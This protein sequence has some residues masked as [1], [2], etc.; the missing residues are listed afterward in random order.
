MKWQDVLL[1]IAQQ[2]SWYLIEQD[3]ISHL[4]HEMLTVSLHQEHEVIVQWQP[5]LDVNTSWQPSKDVNLSSQPAKEV[6]TS[7]QPATLVNAPWQPAKIATTSGQP[8]GEMKVPWQQGQI[9][10]ARREVVKAVEDRPITLAKYQK[11]CEQREEVEK[12]IYD[13]ETPTDLES[14]FFLTQHLDFC[15][16]IIAKSEEWIKNFLTPGES[17]QNNSSDDIADVNLYIRIPNEQIAYAQQ[18]LETLLRSFPQNNDKGLP[19][20]RPVPRNRSSQQTLQEAAK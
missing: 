2:S 7:W 10:K 16:D 8:P 5:E 13:G 17:A 1:P 19:N 14:Y 15:K 4:E 3:A 6:S 9:V 18:A 11:V 20:R 12:R